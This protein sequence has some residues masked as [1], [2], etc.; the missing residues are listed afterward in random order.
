M[1][2]SHG[3]GFRFGTS[4]PA[5]Q[6]QYDH[7]EKNNAQDAGRS[8]TPSAAIGPAGDSA[9]KQQDEDDKQDRA[10]GHVLISRLPP[11][12]G[13]A[14]ELNGSNSHSIYSAATLQP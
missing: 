4:K 7:D 6:Q 1:K 14:A 10:D 13:Y 2:L 5:G 8:V 9:D 3:H 11:A 12:S